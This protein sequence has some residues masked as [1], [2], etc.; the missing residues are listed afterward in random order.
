MSSERSHAVRE[1]VAVFK[2]AETLQDAIDELLS[3]KFD[4]ADLSV[5]ASEDAIEEKLGHKYRS[6]EELEDDSS[7]PRVAY[8]EP[9]SIGVVEGALIGG[10]LYVGGSVG[11]VLASAGTLTMVV[12]AGTVG[13]GVGALI[14]FVFAKL[15]GDHHANVLQQHLDHGGLLLWVG[16]RDKEREARATQILKRHSGYRVHVHSLPLG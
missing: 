6:V 2:S 9:E 16:T 5:M 11:A 8:E 4:R 14:G 10:L 13:A 12:N 3:S 1:A 15:I 7:V